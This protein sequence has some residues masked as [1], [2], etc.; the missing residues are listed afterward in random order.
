MQGWFIK[1]AFLKADSFLETERLMLE[2]AH[3]LDV[4]LQVKTNA[5]LL[6]RLGDFPKSSLLL[7]DDLPNFVIFWDKDVRLA[8]YLENQGVKVYNSAKSIELCDDKSLMYECLANHQV[9]IPKT[10]VLPK[11][12]GLWG[13]G[14]YSWLEKSVRDLGFPLVLKECFGSW[15]EQVHLIEDEPNLHKQ[16]SSLSGRPAVLQEYIAQS[17]GCDIR[18]YVLGERCAAAIKRTSPEGVFSSARMAGSQAELYSL[19]SEEEVIALRAARILGLDFGSVDLFCTDSQNPVVC[20]VNSNPQFSA[21]SKIKKD[22][23]ILDGI[24]N[25]I[26][27]N[28]LEGNR[29]LC[30][31]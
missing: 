12:Y 24:I 15:G 20:E 17:Y 10:I 31:K 2:T 27:E 13:Y 21:V 19:S 4:D 25:Y 22:N 23:I 6:C 11:T 7:D 9:T 26:V 18:V 14:D 5:D 3:S 29:E 30:G 16:L 1:N 8:T 28:F